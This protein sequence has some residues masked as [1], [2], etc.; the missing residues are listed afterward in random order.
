M[1]PR[2]LERHPDLRGEM[3]ARKLLRREVDADP[4]VAVAELLPSPRLVAGQAEHQ[5]P[6]RQ[7]QARVLREGDELVRED[8][9]PLRMTPPDQSFDTHDAP[10]LECDD[11]LIVE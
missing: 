7:D 6:E 1:E 3:A 8:E 9:P 11:R 5:P 4:Q 2:L 10:R